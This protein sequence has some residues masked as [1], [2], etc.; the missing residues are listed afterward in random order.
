MSD[1]PRLL[2]GTGACGKHQHHTVRA[3]G[4]NASGCSMHV[5]V[6]VGGGEGA[7]PGPTRG[8][9]MSW[10]GVL[11]AACCAPWTGVCC[12]AGPVR[13]EPSREPGRAVAGRTEASWQC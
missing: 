10:N 12:W 3:L 7:C 5:Y 8:L 1:G 2:P 13:I 11:L 4:D 6:C 9:K